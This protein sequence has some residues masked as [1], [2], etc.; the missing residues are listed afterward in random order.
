MTFH[1]N[2]NHH[3]PE[4]TMPYRRRLKSIKPQTLRHS[5]GLTCAIYC[6]SVFALVQVQRRSVS[7]KAGG[8]QHRSLDPWRG[9]SQVDVHSVRHGEHADWFC[10]SSL[11]T[12]YH[13][14]GNKVIHNQVTAMYCLFTE[15]VLLEVVLTQ[16]TNP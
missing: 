15:L 6:V 14:T 1:R 12:P 7:S 5:R 10:S 4:Y 11:T 16:I 13:C 8:V 2:I 9:V 3:L